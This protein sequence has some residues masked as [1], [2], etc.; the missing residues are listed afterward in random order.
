MGIN[1]SASLRKALEDELKRMELQKALET[2]RKEVEAAPELPEGTI[3][4]IIR[5]M[6]EGRGIVK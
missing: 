5:N 3:V 6:R 1:I 4:T 2:L